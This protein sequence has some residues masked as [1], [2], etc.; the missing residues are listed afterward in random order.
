MYI[1]DV[2][3]LQDEEIYKQLYAHL[4]E[5]RRVKTDRFRFPKD[6]R[7]S[8]GAG[9]LLIYALQKENVGNVSIEVKPTG[10]P[11]LAG[12]ENLFFNLSHSENMV[13]CVVADKEVG[14]DV[15]RRTEFDR[16][17]ASY[18]MTKQE[19]QQ[20]YGLDSEAE[21]QEMFFRLWTLKESYMKATGFGIGLEPGTFGIKMEK[22]SISVIPPVDER[23]FFFK[24]YY[25]DDGYCY[26]CCSLSDT[27]S[28]GMTKVDLGE[29]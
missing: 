16:A 12:K 2:T 1:A 10:K 9:A 6:R 15:E 7:L 17:L 21:Q 8:V 29:I 14:C 4:D 23:E 22:G 25:A 26:S 27:F 19:L 28:E 11:Y 13:M 18:V 5:E 20:I 3:I 24:E